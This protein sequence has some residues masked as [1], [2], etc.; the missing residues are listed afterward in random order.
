MKLLNRDKLLFRLGCCIDQLVELGSVNRLVDLTISFPPTNRPRDLAVVINRF[1]QNVVIRNNSVVAGCSVL[2]RKPTTNNYH[3]HCLLVVNINVAAGFDWAA[4]DRYRCLQRGYTDQPTNRRLMAAERR[5]YQRSL[6]AELRSLTAQLSSAVRRLGGRCWL[7]PVRKNVD[8]LKYYYYSNVPFNRRLNERGIHFFRYWGV[9]QLP[10]SATFSCWTPRLVEKHRRYQRFGT[11][12]GLPVE[13]NNSDSMQQLFGCRW[14]WVFR[15][16]IR[17]PP[18]LWSAR[19][20][21]YAA[22]TIQP[23]VEQYV[24]RMQL[25]SINNYD[26]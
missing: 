21:D 10:P 4:F 18:E 20:N 19:M 22:A 8:A 17:Q 14:K 16:Y 2:A 12:I 25:A 1:F 9:G 7:L 15:R 5:C 13:L 11:A 24:N 6:S 26:H 3:V 23:A